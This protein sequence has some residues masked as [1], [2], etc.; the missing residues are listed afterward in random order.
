[1][2]SIGFN[3]NNKKNMSNDLTFITNDE[4]GN[5]RDRFATLIKATKNF[6]VWLAIST[7]AGSMRCILHLRKQ[8]TFEFSLG[9][10]LI[11]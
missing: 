6:D 5:L 11:G 3:Q 2:L 1:M 9:S 7:R 8:T 4:A 10:V